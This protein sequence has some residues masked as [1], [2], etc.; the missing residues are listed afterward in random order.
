MLA[1]LWKA[2]VFTNSALE[3]KE[4]LGLVV[5]VVGWW[6]EQFSRQNPRNAFKTSKITIIH[7]IPLP[8][9]PQFQ[10]AAFRGA[11]LTLGISLQTIVK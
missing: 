2:R 3:E 7:V 4:V 9:L 5:Y 6:L 1:G 10:Q 11:R 8:G